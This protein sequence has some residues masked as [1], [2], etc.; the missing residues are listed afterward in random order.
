M[1]QTN[2]TI[3]YLVMSGPHAHQDSG[4]LLPGDDLAVLDVALDA[5]HDPVVALGGHLG[6][7]VPVEGGGAAALLHVA[8]DVL[9]GSEDALALLGVQ[10]MRV[11]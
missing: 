3:R 6:A 5:L 1:K 11:Q 4:V 8:E 9:A 10:A 7:H 2:V